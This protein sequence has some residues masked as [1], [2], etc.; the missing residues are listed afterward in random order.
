MDVD[1]LLRSFDVNNTVSISGTMNGG[2]DGVFMLS[3][4]FFLEYEDDRKLY[5]FHDDDAIVV[6]FNLD[7]F[8]GMNYE[9]A[10]EPIIVVD[11]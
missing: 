10:H 4:L 3:G 1:K 8:Q 7:K 5:V 9:E 6:A 11:Y 2:V